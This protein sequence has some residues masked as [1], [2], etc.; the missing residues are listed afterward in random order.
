MAVTIG[1]FSQ[2]VRSGIISCVAALALVM[3]VIFGAAAK[4]DDGQAASAIV[5]KLHAGL[6]HLMAEGEA[7]GQDAAVTYMGGTMDETYN[8]PTLTA[9]SIGP[10]VFRGYGD[11]E[12]ALVVAAY[13]EFAVANY[14]SRFAKR[15]PISFESKSVEAAPRGSFLV[16]T[17][18][19]RRTGDPVQLSYVVVTGDTGISGIADVLYD[20]VSE[21]ARRRSELSSLARQGA[22]PLATAL[23]E[24]AK[25]ILAGNV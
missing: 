11:D 13:R 7:M 16:H 4:A 18:L 6:E 25:Q 24:K 22:A 19:N 12:K 10:S 20:G 5:E 21:A 9:Q 14:V 15:R 23:R 3:P 2:R 17:Q 8:L 1:L